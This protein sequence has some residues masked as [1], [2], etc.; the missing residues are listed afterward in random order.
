[1][2]RQITPEERH[3]DLRKKLIIYG[4][5]AVAIIVAAI[6]INSWT[7]SSVSESSLKFA[8]VDTGD[9]DAAQRRRR[10]TAPAG[11]QYG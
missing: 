7:R 5:V 8:A 9:V 6:A 4:L 3:R 11:R 1:M 10:K 2:D